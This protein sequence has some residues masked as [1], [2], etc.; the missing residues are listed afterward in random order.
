M[1]V[2]M[3]AATLVVIVLTVGPA[4]AQQGATV[5][6][7]VRDAL[8]ELVA[9]ATIVVESIARGR[10][11]SV[12][13]DAVGRYR[14]A[15]LPPGMYRL[16][17]R[18]KGFR[19][20]SIE[21]LDL[22]AGQVVQ[23][24]FYLT[25]ESLSESVQVEA[26]V[27]NV[28]GGTSITELS[29][30]VIARLPKGRDYLSLIAPATPGANFESTSAGIQVHGASGGENRFVV[31]GM[32]TT[33]LVTGLSDQEAIVDFLETVS[34][35][36][37][38]FGADQ[39]VATGGVIQA[40]TKSGT[41]QWRGSAGLFAT[42]DSWTGSPR[43]ELELDAETNETALYVTPYS[44]DTRTIEPLADVGG[45]LWR[46]RAWLY[47]GY[48][49]RH[50]PFDRQVTFFENG[51]TATFQSR[52]VERSGYWTLTGQANNGLRGRLSGVHRRVRGGSAV[53]ALGADGVSFENPALFPSR[54]RDES[55]SSTTSAA[56]DWALSESTLFSSNVG[57]FAASRRT[58]NA[59]TGMRRQF[60]NSNLGMESVP[61]ELR[62]A[63]G[64]ADA[65]RP[66]STAYDDT[67]RL[68]F[69]ARIM[70][71]FSGWGR[72]VLTGGT[73]VERQTNSVDAGDRAP[74]L[75][76][77]W[78]RATTQFGP[79]GRGAFGYYVATLF[80]TLGDV[81]STAIAGFLQDR[82]TVHDRVT[83]HVGVRAENEH[84]PSYLEGNPGISFGFG[85][86][87]AP[88]VGAA[89][90]VTGDGRWLVSSHWGLYHDLTKLTLAR[91]TFGADHFYQ[92]S[93]TLDTADWPSLS[94]TGPSEALSCP[95]EFLGRVNFR[96]PW[97]QP[98]DNGV[99]H[100]IDPDLRP[101]RTRE[102]AI[103]LEH[104]LRP[105]VTVAARYVR[106]RLDRTVEDIVTGSWDFFDQQ[107]TLVNP[108]EGLGAF[109]Y[110]P[111]RPALPK[112]RRDYDALV[113]TA[114]RRL[115]Q[116]WS[117]SGSY[118]WSRLSGNYSGLVDT[119]DEGRVTPNVNLPFDSLYSMLDRHGQPVYGRLATDRPHV[120]KLQGTY[121]LAWGTQLGLN[122]F[123]GS[124]TPLQREISVDG[125][126]MYYLGRGSDGRTPVLSYADLRIAHA[127]SL[128]HARRL[129]LE[130]TALNLFDQ[131]PGTSYW[132]SPWQ[133]TFYPYIMEDDLAKG[134]DPD[135][136]ATANGML[137]D[138]RY[139]MADDFL[140]PRTLQVALKFTF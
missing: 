33:N 73:Q 86:K 37:T 68:L 58:L 136:V 65:P 117:L 129:T 124:G 116:R 130:L 111:E 121:E 125:Y 102:L 24:D 76:L 57:W 134:W 138:P 139:R 56:L 83:L 126:P 80:Q 135:A 45:P 110:G 70:R 78:D 1:I 17:A 128:G 27:R 44:D 11:A 63:A 131:S 41:N 55:S 103:G 12:T 93:F 118:V 2:R 137:T 31:N 115:A 95:G 38:G 18:R 3:A 100:Q 123:A 28:A 108:G 91:L 105:S 85:D 119:D 67:S 4:R 7:N 40:V 47:A 9:G 97:N 34:V 122:L 66:R 92:T 16:T 60:G 132:M 64:F 35:Q 48:G 107:Q 114:S 112:A 32:D 20:T 22:A 19:E 77:Q 127:F 54:V 88:R 71:P 8:D 26:F 101:F 109:P 87:L 81:S 42:R 82:W 39:R 51:Q 5:E 140:A 99:V 10:V 79:N 98:D 74:T 69:E 46:S 89:W 120:I 14:A 52:P 90:D 62:H 49:E 15:A 21:M 72:H 96:V 36:T 53:P 61:P 30:D 29:R 113:L 23:A 106:K 84:L 94:C 104:E 25:M 43:P 59:P 75:S 13:A 133:D 50:R 6:G